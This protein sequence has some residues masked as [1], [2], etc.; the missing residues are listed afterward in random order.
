MN[1]P[2]LVALFEHLGVET[3]S[4]D[5]TFSVSLDQGA[6]EFGSRDLNAVFGQRLNTLKPNF[7]AMLSDVRRFFEEA[8]VF[9][10]KTPAPLELTLG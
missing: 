1:Y 5:M 3:Q 8:K 2:N 4:S 6:F 7:W 10:N 9:L